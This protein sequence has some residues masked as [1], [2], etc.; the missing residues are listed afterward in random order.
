MKPGRLPE[1]HPE[2]RKARDRLRELSP[3]AR[4]KIIEERD[5]PDETFERAPRPP[6]PATPQRWA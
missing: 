2:E 1:N 5:T 4:R 6:R 3:G